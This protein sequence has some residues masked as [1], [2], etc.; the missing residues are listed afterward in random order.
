MKS[1]KEGD[2]RSM[3]VH[4]RYRLVIVDDEVESLKGMEETLSWENWGYTVVGTA[5]S[6]EEAIKVLN[7]MR[8]DVLLTDIRMGKMSGIDLIDYIVQK[9]P[10]MKVVIIS[11]FSDIEYYRKALEYKV[12]D[13]ILKPS[14]EEDFKKIFSKLK[15]VLDEEVQ[16][17]EKYEFLQGYWNHHKKNRQENF[18]KYMLD[19]TIEEYE[20]INYFERE[21]KLKHTHDIYMVLIDYRRKEDIWVEHCNEIKKELEI[22]TSDIS[23]IVFLNKDNKIAVLLKVEKAEE[24]ISERIKKIQRWVW[25]N[26]ELEICCGISSCKKIEDIKQANKEALIALNQMIFIDDQEIFWYDDLC[27][28]SRYMNVKFQTEKILHVLF[29]KD[30]N[31]IE[32]LVNDVLDKFKGQRIYDYKH[33]DFLCIQLYN[34][35]LFY[36]EV[37][38]IVVVGYS[39]EEFADN[40]E[41]IHILV[42]KKKFLCDC[43]KGISANC[44]TNEIKSKLVREIEYIIQSEYANENMS[45][46]Y[47]AEKTGKTVNYISAVYKNEVGK[48]INEE[49]I[50]YR[51]EKAKRLVAQGNMKMYKIAECIGYADSSYFAKLFKRYTG[52]SPARYRETIIERS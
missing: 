17:K 39:R 37:Q 47:I 3:K 21:Y 24:R 33:L 38:G 40:I 18:V 23:S 22:L 19:E 34:E 4:S 16:K 51:M 49:I 26:W 48:N 27:F 32:S 29:R 1:K 30:E 11:G 12:F 10:E 46:Q 45:L 42:Q 13:Y 6:A 28:D 36:A 31:S 8:A 41:K 50:S 9:F 52:L 25:A 7:H 35:I 2:V 5:K 43:I 44:S 14:C 15:Q 20:E